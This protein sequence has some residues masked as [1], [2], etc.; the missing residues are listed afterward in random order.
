MNS[1]V[2][3]DY[4]VSSEALKG[5]WRKRTTP[6][7]SST[8]NNLN[9]RVKVF[10]QNKR[11]WALDLNL[12]NSNN[13]LSQKKNW[14][15]EFFISPCSSW[16]CFIFS[17]GMLKSLQMLPQIWSMLCWLYPVFNGLL[18]IFVTIN[19]I[20]EWLPFIHYFLGSISAQSTKRKSFQMFDVS[21]WHLTWTSTERCDLDL[22][23]V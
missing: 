1:Q 7:A 8:I 16:D 18:V 10:G 20:S 11:L 9:W 2:Y 13:K 22:Y 12:C 17:R 15:E 21:F 3:D 4:D 5:I 23:V 14:I 19:A 6:W